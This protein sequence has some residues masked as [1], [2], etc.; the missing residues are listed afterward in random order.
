L[1]LLI[2]T[3]HG[4]S[5]GLIVNGTQLRAG[6]RLLVSLPHRSAMIRVTQLASTVHQV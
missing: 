5:E 6:S 3:R 1:A 2:R 4:W